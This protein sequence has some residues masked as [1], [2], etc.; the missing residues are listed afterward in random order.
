MQSYSECVRAIY[1]CQHHSE[2]GDLIRSYFHLGDLSL[3]NH[4]MKLPVEHFILL[5]ELDSEYYLTSRSTDLGALLEND[6]EFAGLVSHLQRALKLRGKWL[7][8]DAFIQA[9]EM[10]TNALPFGTVFFDFANKPLH[11]NKTLK[12]DDNKPIIITSNELRF[13]L[14][15]D[16]RNYRMWCRSTAQQAHHH[17][18]FTWKS[19]APSGYRFSLVKLVGEL[20]LEYAPFYGAALFVFNNHYSLAYDLEIIA[21]SLQISANEKPVLEGILSGLTGKE[22]ENSLGISSDAIRNRLRSIY[23]KTNTNKRSKLLALFCS[24]AGAVY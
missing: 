1:A 8:S 6:G 5:K 14:D 17:M 23:K 16:Q 10:V 20:A 2:L 9:V 12:D 4:R 15:A 11:P 7:E 13:T 18:P 3:S 21:D 19:T 22:L 24:V